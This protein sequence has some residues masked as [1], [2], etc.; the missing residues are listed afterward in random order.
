MSLRRKGWVN[1]EIVKD[2]P[3]S[4]LRH[5]LSVG[6]TTAGDPNGSDHP[7]DSE[8]SDNEGTADRPPSPPPPP[9]DPIG[10]SYRLIKDAETRYMI[11]DEVVKDLEEIQDAMRNRRHLNGNYIMRN[12]RPLDGNYITIVIERALTYLHYSRDTPN[13]PPGLFVT[14]DNGSHNP[15][16]YTGI[17][18]EVLT[19][20][21][22]ERIDKLEKNC[23]KMYMLR[24][25]L[26]MMS[27]E[28]QKVSPQM[29]EL[30]KTINDTLPLMLDPRP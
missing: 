12:W 19:K 18:L 5:V 15:F 23:A 14:G 30:V 24:R 29:Q 8:W 7:G 21:V 10:D 3:Q 13:P 17:D 6:V 25:E 11:L 28:K 4:R 20:L 26:V 2:G 27:K 16:V 22:K 1:K 9:E